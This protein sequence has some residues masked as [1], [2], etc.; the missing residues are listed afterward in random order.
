MVA[1]E[2]AAEKTQPSAPVG[3]SPYVLSSNPPRLDL[4]THGCFF[5]SDES[6][7]EW[8]KRMFGSLL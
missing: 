3:L 8:S 5:G 7:D 4:G 1:L 2:P 6:E